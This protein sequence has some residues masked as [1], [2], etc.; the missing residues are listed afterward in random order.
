MENY[1][2]PLRALEDSK[3]Y[4]MFWKT[5]ECDKDYWGLRK[6]MVDYREIIMKDY[7]GDVMLE[8]SLSQHG[9]FITLL[10]MIKND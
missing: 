10:R 2:G 7:A 6:V 4:G 9:N 5:M 3:D 1:R 8:E